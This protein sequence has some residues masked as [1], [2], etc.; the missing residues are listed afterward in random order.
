[1]A[2]LGELAE[3]G[4]RRLACFSHTR[5]L[6]R[7]RARAELPLHPTGAETSRSSGQL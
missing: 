7:S 1:M 2:E 3:L 6:L 4:G 5:I